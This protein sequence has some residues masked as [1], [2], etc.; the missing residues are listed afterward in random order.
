MTPQA[1]AYV[2]Y[3]TASVY[4]TVAVGRR[5][6]RQG[7]PFLADIVPDRLEVGRAINNLL[8]TGY[9]LVNVA[10]AM[11]LLR[12]PESLLDWHAALGWTTQRLGIVMTTLGTMHFL[13]VCGLLLIHRWLNRR[14]PRSRTC[15]SS[16]ASHF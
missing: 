5:L 11:L 9:Y 2:T 4:V 3:L 14:V 15:T 1:F 12:R 16:S 6:H 10:F 8:L 7:C 13:N